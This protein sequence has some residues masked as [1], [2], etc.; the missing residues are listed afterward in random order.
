MITAI[1]GHVGRNA[2]FLAADTRRRS[3]AAGGGIS[4]VTKLHLWSDELLIAQGGAGS[5][6][7]DRVLQALAAMQP[8][9][10]SAK[11]VIAGINQLA[12]AIMT[13]ARAAWAAKSMSMPPTHLVLAS[14]DV[15]AGL[16]LIQSI[17]LNTNIVLSVS[18]QLN[19]PYMAGSNTPDVT[20]VVSQHYAL[21]TSSETVRWDVMVRDS[22][23]DLEI[24]HPQDIGLPVDVAKL[25]Y[26]Q[27]KKRFHA[28]K[29]TMTSKD[30][31]WP[32][33]RFKV[34]LGA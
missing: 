15:S 24:L 32:R 9:P 7:T 14:V 27:N 18:N 8:K 34:G 16:G 12:P 6:A 10:L 13:Q 29:R 26:D 25:S 30:P 31:Y 20:N 23:A 4:Q 19:Q 2:V 3:H 17:D 22:V 28:T 1:I 21:Q 11:D 33:Y 5:L